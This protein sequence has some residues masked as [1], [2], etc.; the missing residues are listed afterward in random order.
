MEDR[1]AVGALLLWEWKYWGDIDLVFENSHIQVDD[2][3]AG[4]CGRL[5]GSTFP[6]V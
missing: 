6:E 2:G 5:S 3:R 4:M 1:D